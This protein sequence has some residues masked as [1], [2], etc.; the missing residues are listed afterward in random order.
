MAISVEQQAE[1]DKRN[2]QKKIVTIVFLAIVG[3]FAYVS[4]VK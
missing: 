4:F 3:Y 1:I 2:R